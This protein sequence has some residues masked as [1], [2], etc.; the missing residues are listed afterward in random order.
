[1]LCFQLRLYS[2]FAIAS[3]IEAIESGAKL[4][5]DLSLRRCDG[6]KSVERPNRVHDSGAIAGMPS[7]RVLSAL[8]QGRF[9]TSQTL[10][11]LALSPMSAKCFPSGEGMAAR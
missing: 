1:V 6:F 8:V 3:S 11:L 7:Y 10:Q 4:S 2:M 5:G 9:F